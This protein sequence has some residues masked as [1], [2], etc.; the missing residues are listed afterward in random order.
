MGFNFHIGTS[1]KEA[2]EDDDIQET[3]DDY[4]TQEHHDAAAKL[5]AVHRGNTARKEVEAKLRNADEERAA[6]KIQAVYRGKVGRAK[7][8]A[9]QDEWADVQQ[10]QDEEWAATKLQALHRGNTARK[11]VRE[12]LQ[13][14]W[15]DADAGGEGERPRRRPSATAS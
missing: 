4:N 9:K 15:D 2:H 6:T 7:A 1:P 5:Q 14:Q 12:G 8:Q 13:A 10:A 3:Y 11:Q